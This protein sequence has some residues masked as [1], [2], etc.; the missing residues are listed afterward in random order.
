MRRQMLT[1]YVGQPRYSLANW[2]ALQNPLI[3]V[4]EAHNT[5]RTEV[6]SRS[7]I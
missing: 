4:D 1:A 5:K 6:L 2:L 7:D 3:V